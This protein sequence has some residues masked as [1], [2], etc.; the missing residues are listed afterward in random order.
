MRG[1]RG[2]VFSRRAQAH[3]RALSAREQR[4]ILAAI[5]ARRR[6]LGAGQTSR[7]VKR[8]RPEAI[9]EFALRLG[10]LRVFF[11][12]EPGQLVIQAIGRKDHD[13]LI[14]ADG[15]IPPHWSQGVE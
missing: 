1:P 4:I 14:F 10:R 3:W 8:L 9:S 13:V 15:E 11:D 2:V 7:S 6:V 12:I 5:Q